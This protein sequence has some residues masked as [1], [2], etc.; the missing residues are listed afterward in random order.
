MLVLS[1][2]H[3]PRFLGNGTLQATPAQ[4]FLSE[5]FFRMFESWLTTNGK[6]CWHTGGQTRFQ[7]GSRHWTAAFSLQVSKSCMDLDPTLLY[8]SILQ[9]C[10]KS[11]RKT[12]MLDLIVCF[13]QPCSSASLP[14]QDHVWITTERWQLVCSHTNEFNEMLCKLDPTECTRWSNQTQPCLNAIL[15]VAQ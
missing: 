3:Q 13:P 4:L 6:V 9:T 14:R 1:A 15:P 8:I 5:S 2:A 10:S 12:K 7:I 11:V